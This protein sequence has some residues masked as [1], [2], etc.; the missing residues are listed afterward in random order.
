MNSNLQ[1]NYFYGYSN[2]EKFNT[3]S[4]KWKY[5]YLLT[6]SADLE[7]YKKVKPTKL[8][9]KKEKVFGIVGDLYNDQFEK[10]YDEYEELQDA[11]KIELDGKYKSI[12]V[13]LKD[14][15]YKE[16]F[17]EEKLEKEEKSYDV[18]PGIKILTLN[19]LLTW[20]IYQHK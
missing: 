12:N 15:D 5:S 18:P 3:F 1:Q 17:P 13:E 6:F 11:K 9:R 7:K 10:Y 2:D 14:Y 4:F 8:S 16:I 20:L 19:K